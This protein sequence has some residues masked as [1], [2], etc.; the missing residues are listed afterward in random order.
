M[1]STRTSFCIS[2]V[3]VVVVLSGFV[4]ILL[5][6]TISHTETK[7]AIDRDSSLSEE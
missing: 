6:Q 2:L 3:L 5:K 4:D 7:M 1:L